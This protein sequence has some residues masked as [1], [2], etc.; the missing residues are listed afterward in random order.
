MN[1]L[2]RSEEMDGEIAL[3]VIELGRMSVET[4]GAPS[5]VVTEQSVLPLRLA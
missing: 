2:I 3:D 1:D 5:G 4:K